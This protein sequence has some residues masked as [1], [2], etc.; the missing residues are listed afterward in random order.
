[1]TPGWDYGHSRLR[2]WEYLVATARGG[3]GVGV[4]R[5]K[6]IRCVVGERTPCVRPGFPG[7]RLKGDGFGFLSQ[8]E[9]GSEKR[10]MVRKKKEKDGRKRL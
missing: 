6:S 3:G 2:D 4:E 7:R 10:D 8:L 5:G 1:L 9:H